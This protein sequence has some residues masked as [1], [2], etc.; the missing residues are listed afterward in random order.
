MPMLITPILLYKFKNISPGI[1]RRTK[2]NF[3]VDAK[4]EQ[5]TIIPISNYGTLSGY[6]IDN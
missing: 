2:R 1:H 4:V 3:F 5:M 6:S